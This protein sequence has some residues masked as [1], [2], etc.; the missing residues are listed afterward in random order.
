MP[1]NDGPQCRKRKF[2]DDELLSGRIVSGIRTAQLT[3]PYSAYLDDRPDNEENDLIDHILANSDCGSPYISVDL[4]NFN[5]YRPCLATNR[6]HD[7]TTLDTLKVEHGTS[8]LRLDGRV[9]VAGRTFYLQ[10]VGFATLAIEGYNDEH[11]STIRDH[12]SVQTFLGSQHRIW[13]RLIEPAQEYKR[14]Y[15]PF[16]W[17]ADLAKYMIDYLS[18]A[19]IDVTFTDI[20]HK[21]IAWLAL[22]CQDKTHLIKWMSKFNDKSDIGTAIAA[23]I[24]YLWKEAYDVNQDI[25]KHSFWGEVD[26]ENLRAIKG[27]GDCTVGKVVTPFVYDIFKNMYFGH[28]LQVV[29]RTSAC[30]ETTNQRRRELGLTSLSCTTVIEKPSHYVVDVSTLQKGDSICIQPDRVTQWRSG[31]LWYAYIQEIRPT[32]SGAKLDLIWYYKPADTSLQQGNYPF[33]NELFLSDNCACGKAAYDISEV[34]GKINVVWR[35]QDMTTS[36]KSFIVRQTYLTDTNEFITL[37]QAH[38]V[39]N[40]GKHDDNSTVCEFSNGQYVL[41]RNGKHNGAVWEEESILEIAQID[42]IDNLHGLVTLISLNRPSHSL[43]Q[44]ELFLTNKIFDVNLDVLVRVCTVQSF[45][46]YAEVP[47]LYRR[48]GVGDMYF[49]IDLTMRNASANMNEY[50]GERFKGMGICCGGGSFDRGLEDGGAVEFQHAIDYDT[51][52]LHTYRANTP[53]PSAIN[54]FLGPAE[55]YLNAAL[56]GIKSEGNIARLDDIDMIAAGSPCQGYSRIQ[57]NAV[58]DRSLKNAALTATVLSF[59]DYYTP[60][61][62]ILENILGISS[63]RKDDTSQ[64]NVFAQVLCV[65]V[66]L[67]YQTQQFVIDA[68]EQ[69]SFQSR[70]RV[71]VVATAPGLTPMTRPPQNNLI[72]SQSR[73]AKIGRM[74]NKQHVSSAVDEL[75]PF[76]TATFQTGLTDLPD[77]DDGHVGL[78]IPFPD[79]RPGQKLNQ[80][81]RALAT[82]I[83][84]YPYGLGIAQ[85]RLRGKVAKPQLAQLLSN[86]NALRIQEKSNSFSRVRPDRPMQT[87]MTH[88]R[89]MDALTGRCLHPDKHRLLTIMEARRAQG[90]PDDEVVIGSLA[91]QWKI[92]GNSVHRNVAFALGLSLAK[93][94]KCDYEKSL[95]SYPV[96]HEVDMTSLV[97]SREFDNDGAKGHPIL[98]QT[99]MKG[100]MTTTTTM[101]T[102]TT[103]ITTITTPIQETVVAVE[104]L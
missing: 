18:E 25:C 73:R 84:R 28:I 97:K 38:L 65:L 8:E 95:S 86:P 76:E 102:V 96:G 31:D 43:L 6:P 80:S 46:T 5:I 52:A 64:S 103:L 78:C 50:K 22:D 92:I 24:G 27:V 3:L 53:N 87:V 51:C 16:L 94:A 34:V 75:A 59:V 19:L 69:N 99:G 15:D 37:D 66:G 41:Y 30:K 60:K 10:D 58:S 12:I 74:A 4:H 61:H 45:S 93:S 90:F 67:G 68:V 49:Y 23:N 57:P 9:D 35:P 83:P 48:G 79:H 7:L 62:F 81:M 40:C 101:T 26:H 91:E 39:C 32:T 63:V 88:I 47:D 29:D 77:I 104:E 33:Q 72:F 55:Q 70:R 89:P 42:S 14:Y 21:L 82:M 44:N 11:I 100:L 13:Y 54:F 71:F 56:K 36:T 98:E 20:R 1:A 2:D 85:A 17:I